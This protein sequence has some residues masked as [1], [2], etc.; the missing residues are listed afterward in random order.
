M[1]P[2]TT[3]KTKLKLVIVEHE[4]EEKNKN[5][6]REILAEKLSEAD[7]WRWR[8]TGMSSTSQKNYSTCDEVEDRPTKR[9]KLGD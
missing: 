2:T 3:K 8:E 4:E 5:A 1:N 7:Q 6:R 9:S